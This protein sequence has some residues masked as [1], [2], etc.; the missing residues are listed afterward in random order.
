MLKQAMAMAVLAAGLAVSPAFAADL[1]VTVSGIV[2]KAG[3]VRVVIISDPDGHARQDASRN[4]ST[5]DAVDG[6]LSTKFKGLSA[7][8]YGVIAVEEPKI[9]HAIEKAVSGTV[10]APSG[11][12]QQ[13]RFVLAEPTSTVTVALPAAGK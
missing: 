11:V 4:L 13:V 1:T 7:G 2:S 6:V 3:V 9:N 12:S 10:T 5:A 8:D